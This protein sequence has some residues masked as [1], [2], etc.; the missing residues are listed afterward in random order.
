MKKTGFSHSAV[1]FA[2]AAMWIISGIWA[3]VCV[4]R[5]AASGRIASSVSASISSGRFRNIHDYF[6]SERFLVKMSRVSLK[7]GILE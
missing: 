6:A 1:L 5:A 7:K 2:F 3:T 4:A